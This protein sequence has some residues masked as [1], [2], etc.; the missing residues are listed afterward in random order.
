MLE[1]I[2][3][4]WKKVLESDLHYIVT[5]LKEEIQIP[6]VI[7]LDGLVG[8]GKTTL[9]QYFCGKN[10]LSPTYS[11]L[12]ETNNILH[13][14]FYRIEHADE[15]THL[16]LNLYI[17]KKDYFFAE[18]GTRWIDQLVPLVPDHFLFYRV[19]IEESSSSEVSTRD[20]SLYQVNPLV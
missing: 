11:I 16:E 1:K 4:T 12:S 9:C 14:D 2:L 6:A 19:K 17:E 5:E 7:L 10:T 15:F 20:I 8:A 13:A 3:K 18:W